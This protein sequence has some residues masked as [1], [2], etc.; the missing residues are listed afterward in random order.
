MKE[1][2]QIT[3]SGEPVKHKVPEGYIADYVSGQLVKSGPEEVEAV[4][5][6]SRRLI[7]EYGYSKDQIQT[8]PQFRIRASP[9]GEEK[10]PIDI[11]VF[12][13]N[14]KTYNNLFMIVECKR[15][16][17]ADG[18]EQL[19]IYM[20]LSSA[21]VGVWFNGHEHLYIQKIIDRQGNVIYKELPNIP[22][23]G[24][25]IEDIGKFRRADLRP[26]VNLKAIFRD[27]RNHLAG[28]TVGITR[29]ETLAQEI[30]NL[31]FCKIYDEINTAPDDQVTFRA[32]AGEPLED[33][34]KRIF[35]LFNE[36]VKIEYA[37]IFDTSDNI[38][39]DPESLTYVVGELQNFY[40]KDAERDAIAEAFEVFI[41]PALRGGEGQFFTP[42]NVIKMMIDIL[43]PSPR[44][45]IID[46][47]CGS[48]GFL[49]VALEHVWKKLE[50]EGKRKGWSAEVLATQKREIATRYFRGIDKDRFLAK[51]T[52][53]YMAVVGDGRGGVFCENS[54]EVPSEWHPATQ[55]KI[56]L[57]SFDVLL[58]N[59]PHGSKI[60]VKGEKILG[61]YDLGKLWKRDKESKEWEII[62]IPRE[63]QPPQVLF[64]ERCLQLLKPGGRMG[65]I[66]PESLFGNPTHGY[67]MTYLR[68]KA[69]LLGLISM[70][71]ELFQP[72]T[73]NKTCVAF[74][75]KTQH[76]EDY[77]IFMAI[78]K[79]CGHDSRGNKIPYDDVPKIAQNF[80]IF[81]KNVTDLLYSRLGFVKRLSEIRS[82]IFIPK[83]YDPE[84]ISELEDL[85]ATHDLIS[86]EQLVKD[87]VLAI[88][89]GVEIGRLSY[90]TGIVPF[91]RTSDMS[92]WELK[93]DPKHGVDERIYI[94]Y[95]SK[96]DVK[97]HDILM[98]RDGTYLVGTTCMITKYDTKILFQSHIYRLRV[99]KPDLLS[100]FLLL[101]TL[102][103]S[104][105]K[106][107]IKAKQFTQDIIDTLGN[108]IME[109]ILPI[110]KDEKLKE[111][112]ISQTKK[113]IEERAELRQKARQ[114]SIEV[115][116]KVESDFILD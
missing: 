24:Q 38:N 91:V 58:T 17:R 85:K 14:N 34:K 25:R 98:V 67:I 66:L 13:D 43:D 96:A 21:Q 109:L 87:K 35:T 53:A 100:P 42:R 116:G 83:Y 101:A 94:K 92:N 26:P 73:H 2:K 16:N 89:T 113:I 32:G 49:I 52:K 106:K 80:L 47:A 93:V 115:T 7:E 64:I 5:I 22:K 28:M 50:S 55:E 71:E 8:R 114:I 51:V 107:Q 103:S 46:P 59:P 12:R 31:L 18:F 37:D 102:S 86:V 6:F 40:I 105:V 57:N 70:P 9:S 4:Q 54:L 11:A 99:L 112:I 108:R 79:W 69:K 95:R 84:I 65:I 111:K 78:V 10:Y 20:G 77:P 104:I 74:I 90:G 19:K 56:R 44:E 36:K 63:K 15:K 27:I 60:P 68:K 62:S 33:V 110:P 45:Y 75:E 39:L 97:E 30:I 81:Q 29:D 48:G 82:N 76:K 41:G 88:S 23:K 72:Y 1:T 61:Q 3:L